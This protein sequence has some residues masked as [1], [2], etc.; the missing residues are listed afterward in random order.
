MHA[1]AATKNT[2]AIP[3]LIRKL[4]TDDQWTRLA[5]IYTLGAIGQP[6]VQPLDRSTLRRRRSS[7]RGPRTHIVERRRH[8]DG[9]C[10]PC[11]CRHRHTFAKCANWATGQLTAN[12]HASTRPSH[13]V[14]WILWRHKPYLYSRAV[15]TM[16]L[17]ALCEQPQMHWAAF[18]ATA[19]N[20]Y[21]YSSGCSKWGAPNGKCPTGA[22]GRPMIRSASTPQWYLRAWAKTPHLPKLSYSTHYPTPMVTSQH[23]LW[24]HCGG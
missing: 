6:A 1:I 17:T 2:D 24:K 16:R 9:R 3:A 5:A 15:W 18:G 19:E 14:K 21:P 8:I 20:L 22:T 23:L 7:K 11:T 12:G 4:N 13:S 10:C